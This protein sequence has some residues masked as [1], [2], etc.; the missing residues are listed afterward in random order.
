M[1]SLKKSLFG[2]GTAVILAAGSLFEAKGQEARKEAGKTDSYGVNEDGDKYPLDISGMWSGKTKGGFV[3]QIYKSEGSFYFDLIQ[4]GDSVFGSVFS[5]HYMD[6][7]GTYRIATRV[8]GVYKK[9]ILEIVTTGLEDKHSTTPVVQGNRKYPAMYGWDY[10][11]VVAHK[12]GEDILQWEATRKKDPQMFIR[13]GG[14]ITRGKASTLGSYPVLA[15]YTSEVVTFKRV[16]L[17]EGRVDNKEKFP[18]DISG[19]WTGITPFSYNH[20]GQHGSAWTPLI[21]LTLLQKDDSVKGSYF[22]KFDVMNGL[23]VFQIHANVKGTYKNG[24]LDVVTTGIIEKDSYTARNASTTGP[25]APDQRKGTTY[26][27]RITGEFRKTPDGY[28]LDGLT[29]IHSQKAFQ[30]SGLRVKYGAASELVGYSSSLIPIF[31]VFEK[32]ASG[33]E[34]TTKAEKRESSISGVWEGSFARPDYN[35]YK[36]SPG[37]TVFRLEIEEE[38]SHVQGVLYVEQG[39][40]GKYPAKIVT[41]VSGTYRN[42]VLELNAD[43]LNK[44]KSFLSS[45][46]GAHVAYDFHLKLKRG[47]TDKNSVLYGWYDYRSAD[48]FWYGRGSGIQTYVEPLK[49]KNLSYKANEAQENFVPV[50]VY[51][52]KTDILSKDKMTTVSTDRKEVVNVVKDQTLHGH[53]EKRV[54]ML[55]GFDN[56]YEQREIATTFKNILFIEQKTGFL[57]Q[58]D[59]MKVVALGQVLQKH[60]DWKVLLFGHTDS[61]GGREALKDLSNE[62]V[63]KVEQ[64]LTDIFGVDRRRISGAGFGGGSPVAPNAREEGRQLNRRVEITIIRPQ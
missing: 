21:Q 23:G 15:A 6:R 58:D 63:Q 11:G 34:E 27:R 29:S 49:P 33:K 48:Y 59:S 7:I 44:D 20:Y 14:K 46:Y 2:L 3:G 26:D 45:N 16:N 41:T 4:K 62:R 55:V 19:I 35:L 30:H 12:D 22:L 47:D 37:N 64:M 38:D 10:Y 31:S 51:L 39:W 43:Q 25:V 17:S 36:K 57:T 40:K 28:V 1:N 52:N 50:L 32:T 53:E 8:G 56:P 24:N 18:A 60:A 13:E 61:R 5:S 54:A 9:G 42:Q